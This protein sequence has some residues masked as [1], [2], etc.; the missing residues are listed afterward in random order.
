M[1]ATESTLSTLLRDRA[2]Q[3]PDQ[4]A[5]TFIDYDV[6]PA[7]FAE[8]LTWAQ[9]YQRVQVVAEELKLH[10]AAGDRVAIIAPQSLDYVVAFLASLHA[11]FIGVPLSVPLLGSH[12]ERVSAA[13]RDSEPTVILTTSAVADIVRE[14]SAAGGRSA[15][16][17]VEVDA[18]DLET[19]VQSEPVRQPRTRPAYLQYTSGSTRLPAGVMVSHRNVIANLEQV[20]AD[21]FADNGGAPPADTTVISWLPFFH[22]M[23]LI[24]GICAPIQCGVRAVLMSPMAF[25]QRPARWMQELA[26]NPHTFSAAPNFAFELAVRRTTDADLA[27]LDLGN[28]SGIISGSERIHS[29][30]MVRFADR[31]AQFNLA[32]TAVRPSYGLAEATVYVATPEP[33]CAGRT[34]RFE[35][36][37]LSAGHAKRCENTAAG[38]TEL[39]SYGTRRASAVRIVDPETR[40]ENPAGALGEIWVHGENVAMGYWR[41]PEQTERTFGGTIVNPGSGTPEEGWLRTGDIGVMSDDELFIVGRIKDL[42][43]VDGRN[44]YP[45]D[46][47]ATVQE[48]TGGRV[49]AIAIPDER[50]EHL[51]TIIE[52]KDGASRD[53]REDRLRDVKRRVT[54]AISQSHSLRVADI[55]LVP[56]GAIPITTSGKVRRSACLDRYRLDNFVRLDEAV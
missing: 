8:T 44:H 34:V 25:L 56:Q 33:E 52:L 40:R 42:L 9:V 49:A 37:K 38:G 4:V 35:Y 23:G 19:P 18:L 15:V 22:D 6:D 21:Y 31:F 36:E 2:V 17:V 29:A 47:E 54:S 28:V 12:D 30:T 46:I 7:G 20:M 10:G 45:D 11:G 55:V 1:P 50:T 39:V 32:K 5:F 27:G 48:I 16:S 24:H 41:N 14:Y 53:D 26:K 43:I 51:V 13:L 3:Q